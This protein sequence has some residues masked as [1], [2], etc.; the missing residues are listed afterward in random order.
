MLQES[1]TSRENAA[2]EIDVFPE[3]NVKWQGWIS[4]RSEWLRRW[5]KYYFVLVGCTLE[6]K[7]KQ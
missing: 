5:E 1:T 7:M 4:K 3:L 6:R 2:N